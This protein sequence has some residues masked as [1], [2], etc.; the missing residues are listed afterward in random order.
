ME[1]YDGRK[2]SAP[3]PKDVDPLPSQCANLNDD[4]LQ[5]AK[6]IV[7]KYKISME[8]ACLFIEKPT[9]TMREII[10][11]RPRPRGGKTRR[12]RKNKKR[13]QKKSRRNY[14]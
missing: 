1:D 6:N 7:K 8:N 11:G 4:Q 5:A 10:K 13:Q 9:E 12:A 14:K 2:A 3:P